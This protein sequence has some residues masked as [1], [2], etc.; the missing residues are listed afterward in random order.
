MELQYLK[1]FFPCIGDVGHEHSKTSH[2]IFKFNQNI[3]SLAAVGVAVL[4]G[5]GHAEADQAE[6]DGDDAH[7]GQDD[8]NLV[9]EGEKANLVKCMVGCSNLPKTS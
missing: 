5:I 6:D 8:P 4:E 1:E 9:G 3:S 7:D 2:K